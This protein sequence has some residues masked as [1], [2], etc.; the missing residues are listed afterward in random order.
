MHR[1]AIHHIAVMAIAATAASSACGGNASADDAVQAGRPDAGRS[2]LPPLL[3]KPLPG[4][5]CGWFGHAEMTT[6]ATGVYHFGDGGIWLDATGLTPILV[7]KEGYDVLGASP[8]P[9]PWST[10]VVKLVGET[11]FDFHMVRRQ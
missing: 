6:D 3:T 9:L 5:A 8:G 2:P 7:F 10:H 11:R 1:I 4:D